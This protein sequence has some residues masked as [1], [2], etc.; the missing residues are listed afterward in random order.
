MRSVPHWLAFVLGFKG[1]A[2][3][4][5]ALMMWAKLGKVGPSSLMNG[6]SSNQHTPLWISYGVCLL[7]SNESIRKARWVR[8]T[9]WILFSACSECLG[10][11]EWTR[12]WWDTDFK[13]ITFQWQKAVDDI[14]KQTP[15]IWDTFSVARFYLSTTLTPPNPSVSMKT[16]SIFVFGFLSGGKHDQESWKIPVTIIIMW[17]I[18]VSL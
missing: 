11:K 4:I 9:Y 13:H 12:H 18:Y 14:C 5:C 3:I 6:T 7:K 1:A 10:K 15:D 8:G 2:C 16:V 17:T